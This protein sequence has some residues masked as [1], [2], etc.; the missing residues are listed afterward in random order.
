M[1][2]E[3]GPRLGNLLAALP[4]TAKGEV[5]EPLASG[6]EVKIERI[7]S[8]GQA[9]PPEEWYDQER[10]EWVMVVS[11]RAGLEIVGREGVVELGP[12]DW[13]DLPAHCRHRVAWTSEEE[14][15]VW[16]AVHYG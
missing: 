4:D 5:F 12:G 2:K 11:G 3:A 1:K 15:T 14:P 8:G 16:L 13:I 10:H 6:R 7:V 9:S